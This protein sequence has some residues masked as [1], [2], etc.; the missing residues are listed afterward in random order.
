MARILWL[1]AVTFVE[2][3]RSRALRGPRVPSWSLLFESVVRFLRRDWEETAAWE[4]ARLRRDWDERPA[5]KKFVKGVA[6]EEEPLGGVAAVRFRPS[7]VLRERTILFLHGG[8]Y[9]YGS[10]KT[11]HAELLAHL[12]EATR[13]EVIGVDYRLAPEH[14][15]P[16]QLEDATAAFDA[17]CQSG[18]AAESIVVMG[19]SSGGNLAFYL[20]LALRDRGGPK[21]RSLVLLSPWSDLTMPG[22]SFTRND[23][24]DYGTRAVLLTQARRFAGDMEL[25]DPRLS[26]VKADARGLCHT[27]IVSGDREIPYDD[28][29]A[30]ARRLQLSGVPLTLHTATD[31][32]HNALIFAGMHPSADAAFTAVVAF[33]TRPS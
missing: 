19:D 33:I 2:T 7:G 15:Y 10:A 1:W 28:I 22:A 30:L 4:P 18:V 11:T 17:L 29:L 26:P 27:M 20:L 3:A 23:A 31:M 21:P 14:P 25:D 8:S 32:P 5:P 6:I 16:A 13:Y 9:A 24:Y 12:A